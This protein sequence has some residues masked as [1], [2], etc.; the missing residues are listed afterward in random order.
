MNFF[1]YKTWFIFVSYIRLCESWKKKIADRFSDWSVRM[2]QTNL[3]VHDSFWS[4]LNKRNNSYES[5]VGELDSTGLAVWFFWTRFILLWFSR[6]FYL[7]K[8]DFLI[9]KYDLFIFVLQINLCETW[10][11]IMTLRDSVTDSLIW[12][13]QTNSGFVLTILHI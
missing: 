9:I 10:K 3:V 12:F 1:C 6:P 8:Y 13:K 4:E 2:I 7:V 5:F 11:R